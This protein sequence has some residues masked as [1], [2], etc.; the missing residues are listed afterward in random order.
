MPRKRNLESSPLLASRVNANASTVNP[1][2]LDQ[3]RFTEIQESTASESNSLRIIIYIAIVIAVGVGAAILVRNMST[4]TTPEPTTETPDDE[5]TVV[6]EK[7]FE[8]STTV[9]ANSAATNAP[10]ES[11]FVSSL[12]SKVGDSATTLSTATL[13]KVMIDKFQSFDRVTLTFSTAKLPSI[14]V[15]LAQNKKTLS[16]PLT[17]IKDVAEDIETTAVINNVITQY[18]YN[19]AVPEIS[20]TFAEAVEY[21]VSV[22]GN[23]LTLDLKKESVSLETT[24]P[25][26]TEEEETPVV[27]EEETPVVDG[28]KPAAPHYTN[29]FSMNK[30]YISSAVTTNTIGYNNYFVYD[31]NSYFEFS[32]GAEGLGGD[33]NTPNAVASYVTEGGKNYIQL[34]VDNLS[35]TPFQV[36]RGKTAAQI[37]SETGLDVSGANFVGISLVSFS[38]GK[39]IYK[40]EV[41]NKADFNLSMEEWTDGTTDILSIQIKD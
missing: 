21:R 33:A 14:T 6:E 30:Q 13:D 38:G 2:R 23:V 18:Q 31:A 9:K 26:P 25:T 32:I 5:D 16:I 19:S 40:I 41:K 35:N 1:E 28:A 7:N 12:T 4:T 29:P 8:V 39:A 24:T 15:N 27:E 17:G 22:V 36:S 20:L 10:K 11:D 3:A 34:E 37:Q